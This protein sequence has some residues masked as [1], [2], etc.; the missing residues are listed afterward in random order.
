MPARR[1]ATPV[2]PTFVDIGYTRTFPCTVEQAYAWLTDYDDHDATRAGAIVQDRKVVKRDGNVVWLQGHN[3]TLGQHAKGLA[4]VHLFPAEHRW[5]ARIVEGSGR[6]SVY[7]Y[8]LHRTRDDRARLEVHY[9]TRVKRVGRFVVLNLA[10][11]AI[12][13]EIARMWDGFDAA[14]RQDLGL[15][16]R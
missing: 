16:S 12:K 14:L 9:K 13:R 7:T 6:G 8:K 11:P 2:K 4:E 10:R 1:L 3:V 5:E 15:P